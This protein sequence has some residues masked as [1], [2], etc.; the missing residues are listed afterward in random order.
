MSF[1]TG[2][3]MQLADGLECRV[4]YSRRRTLAIYVYPDRRVELRAPVGCTD[5][6]L[7]R[8]IA[9]REDWVR[10]KL[11]E[12]AQRPL[13]PARLYQ[14]GEPQPLLG[15]QYPLALVCGRPFG[16]WLAAGR[17]TVRFG[18]PEEVPRRLSQWYREQ[19]LGVF[20]NRLELCF[21]PMACLGIVKPALRSRP[22]RSRW[23]SCSRGGTI[24][25]NSELVK[26]PLEFIDYVL[27]HELCHLREFN[28]GPG[29]YAL[30]DRFLPDWRDRKRELKRLACE[31]PVD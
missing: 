19:A 30:M 24:T 22:M 7:R 8:F 27:V 10:R 15:R 28:H 13:P 1:L 12:M 11:E 23:G 2:N 21:P 16:V 5:S 31:M 17:L 25:L 9:A 20:A 4:R 29:F 6:E 3:A 18:R 14:D 26:Y